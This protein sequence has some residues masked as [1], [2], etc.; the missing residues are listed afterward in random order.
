MTQEKLHLFY[1]G[2]DYVSARDAE[3]A[4]EVIR[5]YDTD[6]DSDPEDWKKQPDDKVIKGSDTSD[7]EADMVSKTCAEWAAGGA[8][9]LFSTEY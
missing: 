1:N 8:R 7:D 5:E 2:C 9:Y 6:D 4:C 3:H